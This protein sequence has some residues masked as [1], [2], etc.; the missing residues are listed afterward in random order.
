MRRVASSWDSL[1]LS[2]NLDEVVSTLRTCACDVAVNLFRGALWTAF[3]CSCTHL[4]QTRVYELGSGSPVDCGRQ[5]GCIL[6][7]GTGWKLHAGLWCMHV[8]CTQ[9]LLEMPVSLFECAVTFSVCC[10]PAAPALLQGFCQTIGCDYDEYTAFK[11]SWK[12]LFVASALPTGTNGRRRG[13]ARWL[14]R[15]Q[16]GSD[17]PVTFNVTYVKTWR[18]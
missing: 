2:G 8:Y 5:G 15:W 1:C 18:D 13:R 6:R 17:W 9:A 3:L 10:D 12:A 7:D 14:P 11:V 16:G 4:V